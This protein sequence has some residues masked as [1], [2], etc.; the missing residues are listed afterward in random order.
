MSTL[1]V[2]RKTI[3]PAVHLNISM[4]TG[5]Y[6]LNFLHPTIYLYKHRSKYFTT[7]TQSAQLT[8]VGLLE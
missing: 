5:Y 8:L 1:V 7:E 4:E 3:S 6:L 2:S